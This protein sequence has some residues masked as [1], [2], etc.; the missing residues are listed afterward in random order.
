MPTLT[1]QNYTSHGSKVEYKP[2]Q[3]FDRKK[4]RH[5][6]DGVNSVLHCHHYSSLFTQL[7]MDASHL[8]GPALLAESAASSFWG[9]L[10]GYFKKH[11]IRETVDRIAIAEQYFAFTGL[12]TV[13]FECS[14][15][16]AV[17]TMPHSHVDEGWVK[18]FGRRDSRVNFVGEG[19][20]QA[21][22]AAIFDLP[23]P[24]AVQVSEQQS[25]VCGA[26][27]SRFNANWK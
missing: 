2:E 19:F 21:A 18:K 13:R 11:Q 7:A 15:T 26:R 1:K 12:G 20:V 22:C 16:Q 5:Y 10:A 8:G 6:V 25:I 23:N 17:V 9:S 24:Q 3:T 27:E 14:G 4:M